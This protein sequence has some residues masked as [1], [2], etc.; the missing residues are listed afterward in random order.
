MGQGTSEVNDPEVERLVEDIEET[1][2][3]MTGTVEEIGDRLDPSNIVENAKETVK[4]ATVGK[5][6]D[7]AQSAEQMAG[8]AT[9]TVREVSSSMID[10]ITRNPIPAAMVGLGIGWLVMSNRSNQNG[11]QWRSG[12]QGYRS[13]AHAYRSGSDYGAGSEYGSQYRSGSQQGSDGSGVLEQAQ[14]RVGSIASDAQ[15]TVDKATGEMS[16]MADEVPYQVR[17]QA[18]QLG[19]TASEMY[20]SNPLAVGAIAVAVGTAIGLALPATQFERR[21]VGQPVSEA[22]SRAGE[23]AT[24]KLGEVE[25]QAREL[26]E[27][28][29]E[30]DR[31]ARPH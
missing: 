24:E 28:A 8:E 31:Q 23:V 29:R 3:E 5:V 19:R 18:D 26:E 17:A 30:E 9:E 20:N 6:E 2:E 13:G 15:Q 25:D 12:S 11:S 4:A 10:T 16:R 27:Q 7:M 22:M 21:T 14:R 1:R